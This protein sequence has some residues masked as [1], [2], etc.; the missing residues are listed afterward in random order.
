MSGGVSNITI[1]DIRVWDSRRGVRIKTAPGR[2]GYV[3]DISCG[4]LSLDN[5]RVG[6]VVKTDY[7]E[8]PDARYDPRALPS[9]SG[10]SFAG[11][12]GRE[13]R[14]P[15]RISGSDEIPVRGVT[16]R[17]MSVGISYKKKNIFQCSYVEGRVFGS[18]FP[19]PCD[20][21]DRYDEQGRLVKRSTSQNATDIDYGF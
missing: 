2:G 11:V 14:V 21:L 8:H 4:N 15:V 17:D 3:R 5:V 18:V 12:R 7:N 20:N 1:E 9:I 13:V 19:E 6:I 10:L 16:L